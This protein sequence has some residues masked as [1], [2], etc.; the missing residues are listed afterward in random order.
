M[1]ALGHPHAPQWPLACGLLLLAAGCWCGPPMEVLH[2]DGQDRRYLLDVPPDLAAPAPLLLVLHGG[3]PDGPAMARRYTGFSEL[4]AAEGFVTAYPEALFDNWNDGREGPKLR[5]NAEGVDDVAFLTALVDHLLE[6]E[7]ID[8]S[9][10]YVVGISNGGFM[11]ERL[12]CSPLSARLAAVVPV[13]ATMA[14]TL[15]AECAPAAPLPIALV[16]G[17]EDPLVPFTGGPMMDG[18]RGVIA[19]FDDTVALWRDHNGCTGEPEVEL[20]DEV[21]DGTRVRIETWTGC[22]AETKSLVVEGGGHTWPGGRA[23]FDFLVGRTSQEIEM[24][25]VA[26][27]FLSRFWR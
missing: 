12:A 20:V 16:A 24:A 15:L 8:P 21:D 1:G 27:G 26:W 17:D 4:G 6:T 9:R 7:D 18:D 19:S 14:E 25:E 11:T 3:G 23:T 5:A 13:I 2:V 22:A 10:I